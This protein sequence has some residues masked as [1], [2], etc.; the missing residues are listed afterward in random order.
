MRVNLSINYFNTVFPEM[1]FSHKRPYLFI[2]FWYYLPGQ[3]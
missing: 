2:K 1:N 3:S